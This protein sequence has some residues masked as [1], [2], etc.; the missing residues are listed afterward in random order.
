[1]FGNDGDD[2]D[3]SRVIYLND[4]IKNAQMKFLHNRVTT[5]KYN[6]FTFLPRFLYEQFSKAANLFFLFT[7]CIQVNRKDLVDCLSY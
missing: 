5:A 3:T 6:A 7:A 1:M 2:D 4:G